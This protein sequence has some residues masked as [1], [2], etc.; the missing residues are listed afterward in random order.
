MS[1]RQKAPPMDGLGPRERKKI[2]SAIRQVWYRSKARSTAVKRCTDKQGFTRCELCKKRTPKIKV[3]HKMPCG[4]VESDGYITR[5]F[6]PS[7]LL[8]CLCHPCHKPK[9]KAEAAARARNKTELTL[10]LAPGA[11]VPDGFKG[12]VIQMEWAH[13]L[14]VSTD[15]PKK[16]KNFTDD[17]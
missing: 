5:L 14:G 3:D 15:L 9:T 2:D 8:Q 1:K 13:T 11:K 10:Y 12:K 4:P 17:F 6:C 16:K 7:P